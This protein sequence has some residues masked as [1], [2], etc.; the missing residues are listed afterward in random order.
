MSLVVRGA[1]AAGWPGF[2]IP[3]QAKWTA[4]EVA[5]GPGP[6]PPVSP[7]TG[8]GPPQSGWLTAT[9]CHHMTATPTARSGAGR[10]CA[11]SEIRSEIHRERE[12]RRQGRDAHQ[13]DLPPGRAVR[14]ARSR[15]SPSG[16]GPAR[17]HHHSRQ[18]AATPSHPR[19]RTAKT[20]TS[21]HHSAAARSSCV[22]RAGVSSAG[23]RKRALFPGSAGSFRRREP[24]ASAARE[25]GS[26]DR[27]TEG[28]AAETWSSGRLARGA[29][30]G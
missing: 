19:R 1:A 21:A 18:A 24:L 5:L 26:T 14:P 20:S 4:G 23:C 28:R 7:R 15:H 9:E 10:A 30:S 2:P 6:F 11:P 8:L 3:S 16:R 22:R 12:L 29:G 17:Q 13:P 25:P 27:Y